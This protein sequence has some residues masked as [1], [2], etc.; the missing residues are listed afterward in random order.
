MEDGAWLLETTS[1][2]CGHTAQQPDR[3]IGK[4]KYQ[5]LTL[6]AS[7]GPGYDIYYA[8]VHFQVSKVVSKKRTVTQIHILEN[9]EDRIVE[10]AAMLGAAGDSGQASARDLLQLARQRKG[11]MPRETAPSK[12]KKVF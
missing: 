2:G 6:L 11:D 7:W 10:L 1:F 3:P 12:Q 5:P 8:D 9:D 4:A